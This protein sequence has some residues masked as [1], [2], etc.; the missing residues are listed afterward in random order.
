M[1]II[2]KT[3]IFRC[4]GKTEDSFVLDE[5]MTNSCSN[6][7]KNLMDSFTL[8]LLLTKIYPHKGHGEGQT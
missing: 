6:Q 2:T 3:V 5:N 1:V 4:P 7:I 8:L